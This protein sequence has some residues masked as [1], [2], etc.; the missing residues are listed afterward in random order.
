MR[1]P[2]GWT[3]GEGV[4][5]WIGGTL[6]TLCVLFYAFILIGLLVRAL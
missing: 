2:S 1:K 5:V 4:A 3:W 6:A